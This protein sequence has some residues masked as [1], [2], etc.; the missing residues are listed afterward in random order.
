MARRRLWTDWEATV[1]LSS[2]T[3]IFF[4]IDTLTAGLRTR[5]GASI[6]GYT[7][8][9]VM[10]L[11][12]VINETSETSAAIGSYRIGF[13]RATAAVEAVDLPDLSSH[14]GDYL[15]FHSAQFKGAGTGLTPVEPENARNFTIDVKSMRQLERDSDEIF[16]VG[17]LV[18]ISVAVQ[19]L[20]S[21]S[22][23]WLAPG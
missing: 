10:G 3:Q 20:V 8:A 17:Q 14:Q 5:I 4:S 16:A 22:C 6:Q 7:L 9:R 18:D 15:Y 23:L 12:M 19:V 1:I 21:C 13:V 2:A 11:G